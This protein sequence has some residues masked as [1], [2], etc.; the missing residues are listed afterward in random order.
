MRFLRRVLNA[1][2]CKPRVYNDHRKPG[3]SFCSDCPDHEAC[4]QAYPCWLVKGVS[5]NAAP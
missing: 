3:E 4:M 2:R 5:P 1:L